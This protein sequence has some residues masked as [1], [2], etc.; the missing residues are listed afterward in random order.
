MVPSYVP[1][2]FVRMVTSLTTS[3]AYMSFAFNVE[4]A[5]SASFTSTEN[6]MSA[7]MYVDSVQ[8][9]TF[10]SGPTSVVMNSGVF[11]QDAIAR[12]P[13]RINVAVFIILFI[14]NFF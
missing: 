4:R 13:A 2:S 7:P 12:V 3:S 1:F 10:I 9:L 11:W 5:K 6:F 8:L 14:F